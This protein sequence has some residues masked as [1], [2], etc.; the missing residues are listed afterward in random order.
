MKPKSQ[1][2]AKIFYSHIKK[3]GQTKEKVLVWPNV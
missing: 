1:Y 3:L 2:K